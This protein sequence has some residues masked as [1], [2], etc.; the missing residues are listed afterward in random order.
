[1]NFPL[2][3]FLV[4]HLRQLRLHDIFIVSDRDKRFSHKKLYVFLMVDRIIFTKVCCDTSITELLCKFK[5]EL[6]F[7]EDQVSIKPEKPS[8]KHQRV[9][10]LLKG[11]KEISMQAEKYE[12][13]EK[14]IAQI[15]ELI[16]PKNVNSNC[17]NDIPESDQLPIESP[18]LNYDEYYTGNDNL[19]S[20]TDDEFS[21][22]VN[23]DVIDMKQYCVI[24]DFN[25]DETMNEFIALRKGQIYE[26]C[27]IVLTNSL[28][29]FMSR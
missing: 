6:L 10:V 23:S 4:R 18:P 1:M 3:P 8:E 5:S 15:N 25:P 13:K 9:F 14:W 2:V 24:E 27:Y 21:E 17:T 28:Q 22:D 16:I 26:V 19:S 20:N 7:D 11:R 12:I 29:V